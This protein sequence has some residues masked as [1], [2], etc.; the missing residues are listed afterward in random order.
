MPT[1]R[2]NPTGPCIPSRAPARGYLYS[3][4]K[5]QAI[6]IRTR[7]VTTPSVSLGPNTG[8][9]PTESQVQR[10]PY[11]KVESHFAASNATI[12]DAIVKVDEHRFLVM[13]YYDP[14]NPVNEALKAAAPGFDWRG[15]LVV[16]ALGRVTPYLRK[17]SPWLAKVAMNN[18]ASRFMAAYLQNMH[19]N[20][21]IP[22]TVM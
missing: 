14:A 18:G 21:P 13:A 17:V 16:V 2:R 19:M 20:A 5:A 3:R 9:T 12:H 4:Y 7:T 8:L 6:S 10:L 1:L 15:E 22:L 11:L